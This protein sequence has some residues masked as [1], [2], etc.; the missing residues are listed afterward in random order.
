MNSKNEGPADLLARVDAL[1]RR[2]RELEDTEA[3][4]RL[5]RAYG[6]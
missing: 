6:Y 2:V 4:N 1:E 3:I 5:T